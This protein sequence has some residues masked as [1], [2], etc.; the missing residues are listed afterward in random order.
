M[1]LVRL[2]AGSFVDKVSKLE[3]E[4]PSFVDKRAMLVY[5]GQFESMDGPVEI[6]D[7]H[8]SKL[9][10]N[11]NTRISSVSMSE[12]SP[13][14]MREFAPVQLDHSTSATMTVGRLIGPLEIGDYDLDGKKVK[15]LF[16]RL[17]VLGKEN[18][19]KVMDGRWT[20]LS[21]GA[22]L[23][24]GRINE[25]TITPFPAAPNAAMLS[26]LAS[27]T[28]HGKRKGT[29]FK[30]MKDGGRFYWKVG[31]TS[32]GNTY[33]TEFEAIKAAES[34]IDGGQLS[35]GGS[36]DKEKMKK[37]LME[38]HKMSAEDADKKMSEMDDAA[39]SQLSAEVDE[40]EKKMAA[41]SED[42]EKEAKM[43]AKKAKVIALSKGLKVS[44]GKIR[45]EARKASISSKLSA[46]F[47]EGRL[48]AADRKGIDVTKLAA[49]DDSGLETVL[50]A[51]GAL[52]PRVDTSVR[53]TTKAESVTKIREKYRLARMEFESRLNMPSKREEAKTRLAKLSE[54]ESKEVKA[55]EEGT[56]VHIDTTP[57]AHY[58]MAYGEVCKMLDEGRDK[59]AVKAAI[60]KMMDESKPQDEK[61]GA[62]EESEKRMSA[63]ADEVK[64]MQTQFQELIEL[65]SGD[66]GIQPKDLAE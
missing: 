55:A 64:Q 56:T 27:T 19:E 39:M 29:E 58:E 46:M 3:G 32:G 35:S 63:L 52:Q 30:I 22:D 8:V 44:S 65:M 40:H 7:D 9:C 13:E 12:G 2:E 36:M 42:K 51:L 5:A 10:E 45:L 50:S 60:K 26:K 34:A 31:G 20:H 21:I 16:G 17:R 6:A 1:K 54:E 41:E 24:G 38:H 66:L 53:G 49:L 23:E 14:S 47:K 37:H 59:E 61:M 25:L 43:A 4:T 62:S 48:T 11:Y 33:A 28:Y 18:V 57:H 15:A